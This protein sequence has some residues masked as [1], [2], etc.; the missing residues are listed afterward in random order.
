MIKTCKIVPVHRRPVQH[1]LPKNQ[2]ISV[3]SQ[4]P[5]N[6]NQILKATMQASVYE[7]IEGKGDVLLT[8]ENRY[9]D[10]KKGP[11]VIN[12]PKIEHYYDI[13]GN[14]IKKDEAAVEPQV[15]KT[16]EVPV[17]EPEKKVETPAETDDQKQ[18]ENKEEVPAQEPENPAQEP[19]QQEESPVET[20]EQEKAET[21]QTSSKNKNKRR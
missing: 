2:M 11:F 13:N 6:E 1:I 15:D 16:P 4:L 12:L 14:E 20:V 9:A 19:E 18:E 10:N 7:V 17:Q 5:L 21:Q 3:P 8:R